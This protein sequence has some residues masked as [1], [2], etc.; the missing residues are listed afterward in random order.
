MAANGM[1]LEAFFLWW[2]PLKLAVFYLQ[3]YLSWA[4]HRDMGTG[5]YRD[6]RSFRSIGGTWWTSGMTAHV[7]HH[8]HPRIPMD[9]TP[10]AFKEMLPVLRARQVDVAGR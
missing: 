3:F 9:R 1:A 10:A 5:R 2:L 8:L 7:V 6:T 4:P